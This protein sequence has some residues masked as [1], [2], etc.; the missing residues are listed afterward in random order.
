MVLQA[1]HLISTTVYNQYHMQSY[2]PVTYITENGH[3][4]T[5]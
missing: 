5:K 3:Y 2:A 1:T 4:V